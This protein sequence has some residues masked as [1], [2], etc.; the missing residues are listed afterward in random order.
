MNNSLEA[1]QILY[2]QNRFQEAFRRSAEYWKPSQSVAALSLDELILG[3]RLAARLGGSRLSR[4][5]F[6]TARER[7]PADAR[8]RYFGQHLWTKGWNLFEPLREWEKSPS[9]I[10]RTM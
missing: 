9:W 5:L 7:Y 2:D 3:G 6:R 1:I 10:T 4:R 8:A